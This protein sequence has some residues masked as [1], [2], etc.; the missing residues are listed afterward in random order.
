MI[1]SVGD[2]V[3]KKVE[4]I[5]LADKIKLE[6]EQLDQQVKNSTKNHPLKAAYLIWQKPY[7]TAGGDTFISDMLERAG[8]INLFA[9]AQRYPETSLAE[10]EQLGCEVL[11]LSSEPFPFKKSHQ[12]ELQ[13]ALPGVRYC[14][15]TGKCSAG[16]AA[17]C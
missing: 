13:S 3:Q 15:P 12:E 9:G 6:F 16:M 1:I 7:M 8:F 17:G 4:A 10:L 11:L 14:W 2:L 5:Q